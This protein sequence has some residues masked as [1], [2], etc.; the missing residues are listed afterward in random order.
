MSDMQT[1]IILVAAGSGSRMGGGL[2]KQWRPLGGVPVL[3]HTRRA[4]QQAGLDRIIAAIRPED[5]PRAEALA[6]PWVAGGDTRA[7]S[8]RAALDHLASAPPQRVLIH[9]AARPLVSPALIARVLAALDEAPAAAPAL[10]VTDALWRGENGEVRAIVPR[11]GLFRAQTPQGFDYA[12]IR[13]AH[14]GGPPDAADDVEIARA[15]GLT[16]RIVPGDED[17]LKLTYPQDFDRA[18][19]ILRERH[20]MNV[21]Q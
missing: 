18:A 4:F 21:R 2:P 11:A 20:E 8:V 6:L 3:V 15:A 1:A 16:V 12:A 14:A 13:A 7:A 17:N 10:P 5:A 19:A 9:D